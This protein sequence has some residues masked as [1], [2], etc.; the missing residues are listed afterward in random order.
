MW[1]FFCRSIHHQ[2]H[3]CHLRQLLSS[4]PLHLSVQEHN[5]V[6]LIGQ[7]GILYYA[8][9]L[10]CADSSLWRLCW[11]LLEF[12]AWN[13]ILSNLN[14]VGHDRKRYSHLLCMSLKIRSTSLY[15]F[16][17]SWHTHFLFIFCTHYPRGF[18]NLTNIV[19][20]I[21]SNYFKLRPT[22]NQRIRRL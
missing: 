5:R 4:N 7:K 19:C 17:S 20:E 11:V 14:K 22:S 8:K 3:R 16:C 9:V 2:L 12:R 10:S 21:V 6:H 1:G 13:R 18:S 15:Y